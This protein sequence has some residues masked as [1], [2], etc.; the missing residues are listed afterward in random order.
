MFS[1]SHCYAVFLFFF[2]ACGWVEP[3]PARLHSS[4]LAPSD[5]WATAS[6]PGYCSN[7]T[8]RPPTQLRSQRVSWQFVVGGQIGEG[9]LE[10]AA[11]ARLLL[12]SLNV[13]MN[14]EPGLIGMLDGTMLQLPEE[15]SSCG[16]LQENNT[17]FEFFFLTWMHFFFLLISAV[18]TV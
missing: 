17:W 10:I 5:E 4:L 3:P 7:L 9:V 16:S 1:F 15:Q 14:L 12:L 18:P 11:A 13:F 2:W 6:H 8:A